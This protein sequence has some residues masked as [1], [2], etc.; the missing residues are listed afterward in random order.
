MTE[1]QRVQY[2]ARLCEHCNTK[3]S[4]GKVVNAFIKP[5][6]LEDATSLVHEVVELDFFLDLKGKLKSFFKQFGDRRGA[7]EERVQAIATS[8]GV[9]LDASEDEDQD[10][11]L[12]YVCLTNHDC[13]CLVIAWC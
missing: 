6:P 10:G 4:A 12:M 11:N 3:K 8:E 5:L 2:I 9:A 7:I 1:E 13:A